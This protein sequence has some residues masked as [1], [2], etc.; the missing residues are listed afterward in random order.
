VKR[1]LNVKTLRVAGDPKMKV[2]RVIFGVGSGTPALSADVDA[3]IGGEGIETDGGVDSTEYA[4]D[5]V[6]L[7]MPKGF[8]ILGH[9]VSEEPGMDSCAAWLRTFIKDTPIKF[10]PAGEPFWS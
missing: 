2:K 8:I 7:G 4:R 1:L 6:S 10:V 5:G 3:A 9:L